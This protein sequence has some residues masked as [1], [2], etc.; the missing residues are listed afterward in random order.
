MEYDDIFELLKAVK[1]YK[2]KKGERIIPSNSVYGTHV[3][4]CTADGDEPSTFWIISIENLK[5]SCPSEDTKEIYQ[6][7][8]FYQTRRDFLTEVR[9]GK[10]VLEAP[11]PPPPEP[12]SEE[13][14]TEDDDDVQDFLDM[15]E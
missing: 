9:K 4:Y 5:K 15:F 12:E 6:Q 3:G 7:M 10:L 13:D 11:P 2:L 1:D 8:R 14:A